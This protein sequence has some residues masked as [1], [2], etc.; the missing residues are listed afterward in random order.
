M[1]RPTFPLPLIVLLVTLASSLSFSWTSFIPSASRQRPTGSGIDPPS[2][3]S[4]PNGGVNPWFR[5]D[6]DGGR[7]GNGY[8][9]LTSAAAVAT[10]NDVQQQRGRE[11]DKDK[12][13]YLSQNYPLCGLTSASISENGAVTLKVI[14]PKLTK[15]KPLIIQG[16]KEVI[17]LGLNKTQSIKSYKKELLK[18]NQKIPDNLMAGL[19]TTYV[20]VKCKTKANTILKGM[21][22]KPGETFKW[23]N[24]IWRQLE[25]NINF[26]HIKAK[27]SSSNSEE[28]R[29]DVT[30]VEKPSRNLEYG[31]NKNL[32]SGEWEGECYF[33]HSN[34]LGGFERLGVEGKRGG[35]MIMRGEIGWRVKYGDDNL[36]K[37]GG[38]E[39]NIF[40]DFIASTQQESSEMFKVVNNFGLPK[41]PTSL[42]GLNSLKGRLFKAEEEDVTDTTDITESSPFSSDSE[43]STPPLNKNPN[44]TFARRGVSYTLKKPFTR[45]FTNSEITTSLEQTENYNGD[46]EYLGQV[47]VELGP[48]VSDLPWRTSM[49]VCGEGMP[50]FEMRRKGNECRIRG[51]KGHG[52]VSQAAIGTL[53]LRIPTNIQKKVLK[54]SR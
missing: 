8:G 28:V 46:R 24:N 20:P 14:E 35:E 39:L 33:G 18:K 48:V 10:V 51:Y 23:D 17:D 36:G 4:P 16:M 41:I 37:K 30:V 42:P 3:P 9:L 5:F 19:N 6:G 31:V 11:E 21:N 40:N 1:I 12:Q 7:G 27:I 50:N 29:I 54:N 32:Y 13:Y 43:T 15:S 52:S 25:N 22:L 26:E 53:E 47:N 38:Y 44:D 49:V 34:F 2:P 45:I